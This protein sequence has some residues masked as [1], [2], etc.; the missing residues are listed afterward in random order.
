MEAEFWLDGWEAGQTAFDQADPHRWLDRWW[1]TLD[2]ATDSTVFVP[3]SGRSVD[4]VWLAGRGH[5]VIGVE[6][7]P[8]A[9]EGFFV[10]VELDPEIRSVGELTVYSAGPY[11]LWCGDLFAMPRSAFESVGAVYD[12]ASLVALPPEMRVRYAQFLIEVLSPD[13][14]WFLVSFSYD[15]SEMDGPPHSVPPEEIA[16]LFGSVYEIESV[17]DESVIERAAPL[18]ERGL[19]ALRETLSILRRSRH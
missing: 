18:R 9:V 2:L 5:R 13:V 3:L 15:Q 1:P 19:S 14:P 17:V 8:I 4:M 11:E 10:A 12:R 16:D 7:S 6:L